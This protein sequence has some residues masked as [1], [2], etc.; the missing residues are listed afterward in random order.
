MILE[1]EY[2]SANRDITTFVS[3]FYYNYYVMINIVH[4]REEKDQEMKCALH[5]YTITLS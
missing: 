2:N 3:K 1:C 4:G 5:F